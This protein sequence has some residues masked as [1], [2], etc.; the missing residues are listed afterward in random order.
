MIKTAREIVGDY[1]ESSGVHCPHCGGKEYPEGRGGIW[2]DK[3]AK[4]SYCGNIYIIPHGY[5]RRE[6]GKVLQR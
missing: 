6:D 3:F 2:K 5:T 1:G 4:C